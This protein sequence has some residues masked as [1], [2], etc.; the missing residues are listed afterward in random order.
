MKQYVLVSFSLVVLLVMQGCT[1]NTEQ[2]PYAPVE[3]TIR[4]YCPIDGV[5][6]GKV[7]TNFYPANFPKWNSQIIF[8]S[9]ASVHF[10]SPKHMFYYFLGL[11]KD[12]NPKVWLRD[13]SIVAAMYV[14]DFNT[15]EYIDARKAYYVVG[16][17]VQGPVGDDLVPFKNR[18]DAEAFKSKHGGKILRFDDV[19]IEVL[20]SLKYVD[21][22]GRY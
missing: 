2:N 9:G 6:P 16:S 14:K 5:P 4:D 7:A 3:P 20:R 17:D 21:W 11:D 15:G 1:S 10:E 8:K 19:N 18:E 13:I 12:G 22:R